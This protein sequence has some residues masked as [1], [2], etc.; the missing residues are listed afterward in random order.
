MTPIN[1]TQEK[2]RLINL[3]RALSSPANFSLKEELRQMAA[4][5]VIGIS[6]AYRHTY[7]YQPC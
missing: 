6:S 4:A 7:F 1:L 5:R 2:E 3:A